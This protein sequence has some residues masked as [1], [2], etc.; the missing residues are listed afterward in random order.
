MVSFVLK[1]E[2]MDLRGLAKRFL[3]TND[4]WSNEL[5]GSLLLFSL[6]A[7]FYNSQSGYSDGNSDAIPSALGQTHYGHK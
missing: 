4:D 6:S 3:F 2:R 5:S 7:C 1:K